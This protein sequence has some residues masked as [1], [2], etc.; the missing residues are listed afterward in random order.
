MYLEMVELSQRQYTLPDGNV[1]K[2]FFNLLA[3]E[4]EKRNNG[5]KISEVELLY[6]A[7]ILQRKRMI[8]RGKDIRPLL[9]RRMDMWEN[10]EIKELLKE[11]KSVT[12]HSQI[13]EKIWMKIKCFVFS[14]IL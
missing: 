6:T 14:I 10:N 9:Q 12:S 8:N 1:G 7:L 2:R 3:G 11:A 13:K 4:I 5:L